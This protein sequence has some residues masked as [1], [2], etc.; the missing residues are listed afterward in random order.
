MEK[1]WWNE[2][3]IEWYERASSLSDFHTLLSK[4]IESLVDKDESIIEFGCGL[5][6]VAE[7]LTTDGYTISAYD[8]D[9]E[10]I[11]RAKQRSGLSIYHTSD[12]K[13]T[14]EKGDVVLTIFF[15]RLWLD[16]NLY[17]LLSHCNKRLI[18]IHSL[19]SGQ[20]SDLKARYTPSLGESLSFLREKGLDVHGKEITIPFHQPLKSMEEAELFIRESYPGKDPSS[21]FP[22]IEKKRDSK[23]PLS[24]INYKRMVILQIKA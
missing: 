15:G 9:E 12:Y 4:E 3:K 1:R 23:Y 20:N 18:S 11:E 8:I 19:H 13:E 21:Y 17:S 16:D 7:K 14:D 2:R 10:V 24:L 6:Y 22:Y 5:G